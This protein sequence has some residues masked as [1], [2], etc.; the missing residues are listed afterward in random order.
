MSTVGHLLRPMWVLQARMAH[1]VGWTE[2][3]FIEAMGG[4]NLKPEVI[5]ELRLLW[6]V[7][8]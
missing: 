6:R 3:E 5:T 8:S 2:D 4:E 7:E 1:R